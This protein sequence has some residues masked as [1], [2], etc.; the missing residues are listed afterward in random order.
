LIRNCASALAFAAALLAP[1]AAPSLAHA[2]P[3]LPAFLRSSAPAV[4]A[5]PGSLVPQPLSVTPGAGAFTVDNRTAI[6]TPAGDIYARWAADYLSDLVARSRGLKL[7]VH[8]GEAAGPA[9]RLA[10]SSD[11]AL[12]AEAYALDVSPS[13]VVVSARTDAGLYYGV[14]TLWQLLA[15]TDGEASEIEIPAVRIADAPRYSW[16]GLG[17]DSV[18]HFQSPQFVE[19][20]IDAMALHKLNVLHWRFSDDQGWRLEVPKHP[21]LTDVGAWRVPAGEGPAHDIDPKTGKPRLYGGFY[22]EAEIREVVRYAQ[23]RNVTIVPEIDMPGHATALIV[24]YPQLASVADPPTKVPSDWGI[25]PNLLNVDDQTFDFLFDVLDELT[26]LFPGRYI[27]V[28]GDEAVKDQWKASP[29]IQAKMRSLGI[30]T[31]DELQGWFERRIEA[32]LA[33]RGRSLIGWDEIL[34]GGLGPRATVMSWRGVKGA[35]AAARLGHDAVLAPDPTLYFDHVNDA[36]PDQPPGRGGVI[37]LQDVYEFS[38]APADLRPDQR[39]HVLGLEGEIWTEHIRTEERVGLMSF[40]R[41][42]AIAEDGWSAPAKD[43][44]AFLARM[45]ATYARLRHLGFEA[46]DGPFEPHFVEQ[47]H[48]DGDRVSV[49]LTDQTGVGQI[50][51][52]LDGSEPTPRSTLYSGPLELKFPTRLRARTF[53]GTE[54][55]S[56]TLERRLD[57]LSVRRRDSR[58]LALCTS[59]VALGLEDDAPVRGPRATFLVDI[60]NP[61]WIWRDADLTGIGAISASVGQLPFNFQIGKDI[62]SIKFRP[63]ATP[64]GELEV[65]IDGCD[66]ERIAVL[67]LAT[68]AAGPE[69]TAL[70]PAPIAARSGRHDLCFTFT[71]KG[72]DPEWAIRDVG[73]VPAFPQNYPKLPRWLT[74]AF[75]KP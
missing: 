12:P 6:E 3:L 39:E 48:A 32:H 64:S 31:E 28:G 18:R 2:A 55:L 70:A 69:A 43:W 23:A 42:A 38:L 36:G 37:S 56:R 30:R 50:R 40:P 68:A 62:E 49:T 51:Y 35:V 9:V 59:K 63:P 27:H 57:P 1:A 29:A 24:A 21:R 4:R 46:S 33:E 71:Q 16:R 58:E 25:Y 34:E 47:L 75:S 44:P 7:A 52:T 66:G 61:C 67:P 19:K 72:V 17:L 14:V 13:G 22:T 26:E 20:L 11:P 10:R 73:L 45:P 54:P 60:E 65:R 74:R 5:D 53:A 41:A 15:G 8:E